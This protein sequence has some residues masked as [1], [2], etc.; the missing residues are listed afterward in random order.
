MIAAD[1]VV[2]LAGLVV[3]L[4]G[5]DEV[6]G[7]IAKSLFGVDA[8]DVDVVALTPVSAEVGDYVV[9][10]AIRRLGLKVELETIRIGAADQHVSAEATHEEVVAGACVEPIVAASAVER[11]APRATN[12]KIATR[13]PGMQI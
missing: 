11:I 4:L 5:A 6:E 9:T 10:C 1:L 13:R 7:L 12:K 3:E 8:V 2:E